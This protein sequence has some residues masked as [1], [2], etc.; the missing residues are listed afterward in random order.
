MICFFVV[1]GY[2]Y[3]YACAEYYLEQNNCLVQQRMSKPLFSANENVGKMYRM[4]MKLIQ[5]Y[6][7]IRFKILFPILK[8]GKQ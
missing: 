1:S 6:L 2:N 4:I 5:K 7:I 8:N 3:N